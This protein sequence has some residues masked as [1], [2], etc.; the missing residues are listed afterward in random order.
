MFIDLLQ[1]SFLQTN[2]ASINTYY[3]AQ[4]AS[5]S[6]VK[7]LVIPYKYSSTHVLEFN[8]GSAGCT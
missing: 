1:V 6:K 4:I 8:I 2:I 7:V 3:K 5:P